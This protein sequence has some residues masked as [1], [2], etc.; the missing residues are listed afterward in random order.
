MTYPDLD[1]ADLA[2]LSALAERTFRDAFAAENT[3]EDMDLHCARSFSPA[4]QA[5]E[6]ADR[7]MRTVVAEVD[8]RLVGFAQIHLRPDSP[9]CVA[10]APAIEL[11]RIY[12]EREQHGT[13]LAVDL[14]NHVFATADEVGA[15]A[16]W[17]GVWERNPRALRFYHRFGFREVGAHE[18]LLGTDPQRDLVLVCAR[19]ADGRHR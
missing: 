12:V 14:M 17:L 4:A 18:F 2:E 19:A 6:L 7:E 13:G 11:Y 16:V 1:A 8:G 3:A 5:A 9:P 15:A 10:L